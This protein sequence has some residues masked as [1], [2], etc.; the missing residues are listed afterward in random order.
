MENDG[1]IKYFYKISSGNAGLS[2]YCYG[3]TYDETKKQATLLIGSDDAA[4]K[5][6]SL[7]VSSVT[8]AILYVVS[9]S[10]SVQRGKHITL[11]TS[12]KTY[13]TNLAHN[14]LRAYGDYYLYVGYSTGYVTGLQS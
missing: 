14:T 7:A 8:D 12:S 13:T 11:A 5:S 4:F 3:I 2:T 1:K 6:S 9:D 10:G